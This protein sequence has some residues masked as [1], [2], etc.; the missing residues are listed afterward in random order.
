MRDLNPAERV[1]WLARLQAYLPTIPAL[2]GGAAWLHD[3]ME[4]QKA[5]EAQ[6]RPLHFRSLGGNRWAIHFDGE[7]ARVFTSDLLGVRA[8]WAVIDAG[9][10]GVPVERFAKPGA[11]HAGNALRTALRGPAV[12]WLDRIVGCPSLAAAVVRI[13]VTRDGCAR[14]VP[15]VSTPRIVTRK[16][17]VSVQTRE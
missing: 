8:A 12:R 10:D 16:C 14:Y 11:T 7:P 4:T 9:A 3:M 2:E 6:G 13:S 5:V 1:R 17:A 15:S